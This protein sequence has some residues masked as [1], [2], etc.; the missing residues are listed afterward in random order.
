MV[1]LCAIRLYVCLTYSLLLIFQ[2]MTNL[3]K[4][5]PISEEF[6]QLE[7]ELQVQLNAPKLIIGECYDILNKQVNAN[8]VDYCKT[9]LPQNIVDVYVPTNK[10]TQSVSD[11]IANGV[12]V[13]EKTGF[14]FQVDTFRVDRSAKEVEVIHFKIA[15]GNT[16]NFQPA[17]NI[18]NTCDYLEEEPSLADLR[19]GYHS[20]C[21]STSNDFVVF[22]E[23][24]ISAY[25]LIKMPGGKYLEEPKPGYDICDLCGKALATIWCIND[26]A[27][28]CAKC[29][30]ESHKTNKMFE[31]H[32]RLPLL[33]AR[34]VMEFCPVHS[35]QRV[36]YYCPK[37]RGPVCFTCKMEG[38][39]SCGKAAVHPLVP[40]KKAY[41]ER[42]ESSQTENPICVKRKSA[43]DQKIKL[44]DDRLDM[45]RQNA[46]EICAEIQRI[47][48]VAQQNVRELA[49]E[50][51]LLVRS[52]K[53]ELQR[54]R[55]E[56]E[57]LE[58]FTHIHRYVSLP[59]TF[60]NYF[61]RQDVYIDGM[62][63]TT[64]L[65]EDTRVEPDLCVFGTLDVSNRP[66]NR[67]FAQS[68]MTARSLT[69]DEIAE[70][71]KNRKSSISQR[72]KNGPVFTSLVKLGKRRAD[73]NRETGLTLNFTP[74][75]GS[76]IIT[77]AATART[78]YLCF[79][80]K[81][82][83]QTH[84]LFSSK[85]DGRSIRKMHEMIDEI[86]ITAVFIQKDE[87]IFG[88]FA[89]CKWN[90]SGKPFGDKS[91]SFIFS[92][93]QDALVPY[94]PNISD[95]CHLIATEDTLSFGKYD[96]VLA[97]NFDRCTGSIE[98][99]YGIGFK[100]GSN[101]AENFLAGQPL[102]KADVV[103]VWGFWRPEDQ[104]FNH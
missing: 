8:F 56:I 57:T 70:E 87:Y 62:K 104:Q 18:T 90:S 36:E 66:A 81:D 21:C 97:D 88:G 5:D 4:I 12:K 95:A 68:V 58:R 103:E 73:R 99:S 79:P 75:Q 34:C 33:E 61:D 16:L 31:R 10:L 100:Q 26:S 102:F 65:P 28:L 2:E 72:G 27:Q 63:E 11:I 30:E 15:L 78:L 94:R 23:C 24:Q 41:G 32:K 9:L 74:F 46:E 50:K 83:P 20:L 54:K 82:M 38:S 86:G 14:H 93:T 76:A 96:L 52:S 29:D 92:V 43:I 60:I 19:L 64:D 55:K 13:D 91:S 85:R 84:L 22:N 6:G 47:A 48:D 51:A 101:E 53:T 89:A 98:N 39:H 45:I 59:L 35:E 44:A 69:A 71:E 67:T 77:N 40:I 25:H 3:T 1:N 17:T 80:F 49:G 37:C 7:F 42:V